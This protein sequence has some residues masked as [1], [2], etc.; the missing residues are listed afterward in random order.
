MAKK[1]EVEQKFLLKRLPDLKWDKVLHIYQLYLPDGS[2]LR[3]TR[4]ATNG[5][6]F[7]FG[8]NPKYELTRKNKLKPGVYEEDECEIS[9]KKYRKLAK[10]ALSI[11]KKTRYIHK[12]RNLKWEID[13][14]RNVAM[15]TAEIELPYEGAPYAIPSTM[16][17]ELVLNVTEFSQ[18]TNRSL[19]VDL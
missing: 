13:L 18:F 16:C 3:E 10:K 19:S 7:P 12:M 11:I 5:I 6:P 17:K 8:G 14:Y 9:E 15:I 2:R 1:I 4:D